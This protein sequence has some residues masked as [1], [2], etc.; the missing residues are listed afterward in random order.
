MLIFVRP[1][2]DWVHILLTIPSRYT[3]P[4]LSRTGV[5]R[6]FFILVILSTLSH[7][8]NSCDAPAKDLDCWQGHPRSHEKTDFLISEFNPQVLWN[9]FGIRSDV[10]VCCIAVL[11]VYVSHMMID[12]PSLSHTISLVLTSMSYSH[13]ISSTNL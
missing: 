3:C 10:V 11:S 8:C 13:L 4:V 1:Y 12:P 2:L 9:E 7:Q 6:T 5:Q